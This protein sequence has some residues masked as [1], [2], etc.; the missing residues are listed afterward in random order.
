[1][2]EVQE[3]VAVPL[4]LMLVRLIDAQLSPEGT[5]SVRATLPLSPR[6]SAIVIVDPVEVPTLTDEGELAVIVKSGGVPY[7]NDIVVV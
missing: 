1:M 4:L 3:T 7:V 5:L 6:T 2:L